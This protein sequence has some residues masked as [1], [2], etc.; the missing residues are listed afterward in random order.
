MISFMQYL[1]EKVIN[2]GFDSKEHA[3]KREQHREDIH[4]LL[5]SS[6]ASLGG[7]LGLGSGTDEESS[8]IHNDISSSMIKGI[9]RE[10]KLVAV[11]LYKDK[12]GRKS[13]AVGTDGS[14]SGKKGFMDLVRDDIKQERS[15]G[16]FSGAVAHISKK[17][18][19]PEI[20]VDK[21]KKLLGKDITPTTGNSYT[22][23]IAGKP[24]E[25]TGFGF[26]KNT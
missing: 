3:A 13:I 4:S 22:R 8:A 18:G 24:I 20:P 14:Q 1:Q 9:R 10:G 19:S 25:K 16:E 26:P 17:S 11:K 5:R 2:I 21:M 23:E 12:F 15:W 6:Y 7:Y